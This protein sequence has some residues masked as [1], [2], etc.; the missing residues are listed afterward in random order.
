LPTSGRAAQSEK[1]PRRDL[2]CLRCR[3][4]LDHA[5]LLELIETVMDRGLHHIGSWPPSGYE[6][7]KNRTNKKCSALSKN[8]SRIQ[9][10]DPV[11]SFN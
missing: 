2:G 5:W 8:G 1:F 3:V 9:G 11:Y 4:M 10:R 6:K 7:G